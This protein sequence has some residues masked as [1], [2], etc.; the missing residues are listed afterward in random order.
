VT[1]RGGHEDRLPVRSSVIVPCYNGEEYL[2]SALESIFAQELL[3]DEVIVIDDG[4]TDGSAAIA[5]R[6]ASQIR[7]Q[8]Q[9][10]AGEGAA[11]NRGIHLSRGEYIS[12][13]DADD[14]WPAA[15]FATLL[16]HLETNLNLDLV[17]GLV[18]QF[19]SPE[20]DQAARAGLHCSPGAVSARLCG[21]TLVR[22]RAFAQVGDF[23]VSR[24]LGS[25]VDWMARFE[26]QGLASGQVNEVV[27]LRRLHR[28]NLGIVEKHRRSDYVHIIKESLDR[29][30]RRL[31]GSPGAK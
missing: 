18:E 12:F 14:L 2:Q 11:R 9:P 1:G 10:H 30:R 20:L 29:R 7:Y 4:S 23:N 17:Y 24:T 3:P 26:E 19:V 5:G 21:A 28:S 13:L 31:S 6:F 8:F 27:L 16:H 22:R 25:V 15:A